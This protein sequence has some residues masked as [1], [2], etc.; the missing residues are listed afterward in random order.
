[1]TYL[2]LISFLEQ[3]SSNFSINFNLITHDKI[4][5][6]LRVG[7]EVITCPQ[8]R[9]PRPKKIHHSHW[10]RD[11]ALVEN[12]ILPYCTMTTY[13]RIYKRIGMKTK[14]CTWETPK[15]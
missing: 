2:F 11:K 1:M 6:N 10:S 15:I 8:T 14:F 5:G 3:T 12:A 13:L 4:L 9:V 7:M